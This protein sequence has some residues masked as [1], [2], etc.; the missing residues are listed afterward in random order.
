MHPH[1]TAALAAARRNGKRIA[2]G[3]VATAAI[4]AMSAGGAVAAAHPFKDINNVWPH[5]LRS[6]NG[7]INKVYENEIQTGAVGGHAGAGSSEIQAGTVAEKDLSPDLRAKIGGGDPGHKNP[8]PISED[9]LT[10]DLRQKVNDDKTGPSPN[11]NHYDLIGR[12]SD[13]V[14]VPASSTRKVTTTCDTDQPVPQTVFGGGVKVVSGTGS[15]LRVNQSYPSSIDQ[16]SQGDE[17]D[18]SGRW[19]ASAWTVQVSN[20]GSEPI[21]VQPYVICAAVG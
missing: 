12:S 17:N 7:D 8:V 4:L 10:S 20:V 6:T 13:A 9:E 11:F 18:Q 1:I 3:G 5:E 15:N 14:T 2:A 16:V 21:T 19:Q